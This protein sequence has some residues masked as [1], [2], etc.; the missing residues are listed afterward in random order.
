MKKILII[1]GWT[2][3]K[4]K[5]SEVVDLLKTKFEVDQLSIPGLTEAS[6]RIWDL[7]KYVDWLHSIISDK[8]VILVGHSNGGRIAAAYA[9]KY[10]GKIEKLIL[11]D[12]AGI[13]HNELPFRIKRFVFK[14]L[15][16]FG[17]SLTHSRVL[18]QALYRFAREKDYL[19]AAPKMRQTMKNLISQDLTPTL[20]FIKVP[21]LIIWGEKDRITPISDSA[22][23]K[24]EIGNSK[25]KIIGNAGHSPFFTHPQKV[26]DIIFKETK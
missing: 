19:S 4:D 5:W 26:A 18:R 21:T 20:R 24:K 1:H 12:S 3:S 8:K 9:S 16:K 13:F 2:Y 10:P 11:I 14:S 6:G 17:K 23:F 25:R 15:A 22:I 7:D